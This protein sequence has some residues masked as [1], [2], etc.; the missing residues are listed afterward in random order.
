MYAWL[1]YR[2]G[3]TIAANLRPCILPFKKHYHDTEYILKDKT[4]LTFTEELLNEFEEALKTFIQSIF[5][6][7]T[8]F[9][10]TEDETICQYC[11]FE[12]ICLKNLKKS[13]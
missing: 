4:I 10:Q 12:P 6:K 9:N 5:D 8:S 1:I 13:K 7:R 3:Y 2:N 11:E